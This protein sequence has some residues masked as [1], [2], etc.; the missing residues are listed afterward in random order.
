MNA[1]R[2]EKAAPNMIG[3]AVIGNALD[4]YDFTLYGYLAVTIGKHFFP[5][6]SPWTSLLDSLAVF[7][8]AFVVRPIGG[9]ILAQLAD[10]GGR[11][12]I[13]IFTIGLMTVGTAMI[14]F[15]PS[16]ATIGLAAPL[17][18]VVSRLL[19]GLSAGGEFASATAFLVEHAPPQRRGLYGAWQFAGQGIAILLSGVAGSIAARAMAPD[20]FESWGWRLPFLFGLVIGPIGYYMRVK[21]REPPAFLAAR[22]QSRHDGVPLA[23]LLVRYKRRALIG[24]GLVVGGSASLYVLF[25]FMPTYAMRVLGL[26]PRVAFVAPLVAGL[27]VAVF[28]PVMGHISDK[29]GRKSALVVSTAGL[30]LAPYPCFAW[31]QHQPSVAQLAVVE[32]AFGLIFAIGGG[33]F[34]TALA[35]MFPI[36][37]RATGMAVAYNVGVALFGGLA[38]FIVTLLIA[39]TGDPL[40]PVYYVTAC[41]A[42]S[43]IAAL[44]YPGRQIAQASSDQSTRL[45][46]RT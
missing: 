16:Y 5:S 23:E 42:I 37:L 9:I 25:V 24:F 21:L 34:S 33:P 2:Q 13:L 32:F 29:I 28:C 26:D 6:A 38:P 12:R 4:W 41:S 27:T 36:G 15:A 20:Q 39:R 46:E 3:A 43:V 14:T 19:Q 1:V 18:I 44:A 31:L 30:L 45:S 7:G 35:E 8:T 17:I 11:R 10:Q 40:A 22:D